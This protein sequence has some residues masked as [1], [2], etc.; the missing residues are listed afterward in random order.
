LV[1]PQKV[2]NKCYNFVK[3]YVRSVSHVW[4]RGKNNRMSGEGRECDTGIMQCG[5]KSVAKREKRST[6]ERWVVLN[7]GN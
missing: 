2:E 5:Q 1:T 3:S 6:Y 4:N 7:Q